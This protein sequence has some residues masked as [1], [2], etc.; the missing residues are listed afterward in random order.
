MKRYHLSESILFCKFL[1][2]HIVL[3][4]T[5]EA[6]PNLKFTYSWQRLNIYRQRVY[7][8]TTAVVKVG[9]TY[10]DCAKTIWDVQTTRISGQDLTVSD[11][12]GWDA[13]IHQR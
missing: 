1:F 5:F 2:K 11:V 10:K 4:Q 6:D 12:G 7:G 13:D 9:Y 3:L 8:T